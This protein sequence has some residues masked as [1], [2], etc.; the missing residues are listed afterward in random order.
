MGPPLWLLTFGE[1]FF[2]EVVFVARL[3]LFESLVSWQ[4]LY[5]RRR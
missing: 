5:R 4:V 1:V 2:T 3:D